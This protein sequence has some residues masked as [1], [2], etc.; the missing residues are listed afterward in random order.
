MTHLDQNKIPVALRDLINQPAITN[1]KTNGIVVKVKYSDG[2][3]QEIPDVFS[4]LQE[5]APLVSYLRH[6]DNDK[7]LQHPVFVLLD[8]AYSDQF[9]LRIA[10]TLKLCDGGDWIHMRKLPQG[11]RQEEIV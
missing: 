2:T 1:I 7:Y 5:Y 3:K 10:V 8:D 9:A 4:S 11:T 6:I